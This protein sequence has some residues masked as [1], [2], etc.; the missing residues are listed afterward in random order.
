MTFK[1]DFALTDDVPLIL[2]IHGFLDKGAMHLDIE[3]ENSWF[4][5]K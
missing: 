2:G 3:G 5:F 1:A 4:E